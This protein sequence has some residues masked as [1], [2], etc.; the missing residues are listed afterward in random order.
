MT[1]TVDAPS[2]TSA[3]LIAVLRAR[4]FDPAYADAPVLDVY[5]R[6]SKDP[7]TGETEKVDRQLL[8]CLRNVQRRHARL[9]EVL[10]DDGVSAWRRNAKRAGWDTLVAR[11]EKR[12]S[13]GVVAWHTDR[14]MRQ[15]R[16]L[17]R[18]IAF[19]EQGLLVGSCHGDYDLG[20]ADARFT[21][22]VLTAAAAK[23]SDATSRRWKRK[24]QAMRESGH[25]S[26]GGR[27]FGEPG[28][29]AGRVVPAER[30]AAEREA[31]R[32][33]VRGHL[34]GV[35]LEAITA[36]WNRLGFVTTRGNTWDPRAVVGVLKSPRL[37]GF[38]AYHGHPV[39]RLVGVEPIVSEQ[40]WEHIVALFT[41]RRRG[42]PPGEPY[43]LSGGHLWCG[44]CRQKMSGHLVGNKPFAD[45][46]PR[47][48]YVCRRQGEGCGHISI[49]Q[50]RT[51]AAVRA[52]VI[53]VL[54][55]PQH[56]RQLARR[57]AKLTEAE[58]RLSEAREMARELAARLGEGKLSLDRY[59]AVTGPLDA[60]I[61]RL[62][63]EVESLRLVGGDVA[64]HRASAAEVAAEWDDPATTVARRRVMVRS[65]APRG[66]VVLPA[67]ASQRNEHFDAAER[68][69]VITDKETPR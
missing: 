9:G 57:S 65:V 23:E 37:A 1:L 35:S 24:A 67:T 2:V 17:E 29:A 15:P 3:D 19:G 44:L 38:V 28:T 43:L 48:L 42:R 14:L 16:D 54:A 12:T 45:G 5:G 66:I 31:I 20:D 18:L 36:E 69:E 40:D 21:L 60:R 58:G 13:A 34:D 32:W 25:K 4:D 46:S 59:D 51:D 41:A 10:R 61:A 53:R 68:L 11:L 6:I 50:P 62:A 47:R 7:E 55:D 30:V 52:L 39:G 33:A 26:G 64:T 22:R 8:D 27:A 49:S 56:A 63:A